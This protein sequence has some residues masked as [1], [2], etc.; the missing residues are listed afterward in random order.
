MTPQQA[1]NTR[2][3]LEAMQG[4]RVQL[5]ASDIEVTGS[6]AH[7]RVTGQWLYNRGERLNY[8]QS[9]EFE[10]RPEGWRIVAIR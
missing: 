8:N 7:A 9:F 4:L 3:A 2:V 5:T 6:A 1:E 10:L